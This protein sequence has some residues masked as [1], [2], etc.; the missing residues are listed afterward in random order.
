MKKKITTLPR[1]QFCTRFLRKL[2]SFRTS[3]PTVA[4]IL[5]EPYRRELCANLLWNC[6]TAGPRLAG[7]SSRRRDFWTA[8][9]EKAIAGAEALALIAREND[10]PDFAELML[11]ARQV[12]L[13]LQRR[14]LAAFPPAQERGRGG[15]DWGAVLYARRMLEGYLGGEPISDATLATLL[16]VA[17]EVLG[18][19]AVTK[20]AVRLGLARLKERLPV[21]EDTLTQFCARGEK[22]PL[23]A[24]TQLSQK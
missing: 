6:E 13:V 5:K 21:A 18:R 4:L 17:A 22:F 1:E 3:D 23:P 2:Q 7:I 8:Q 19:K 20:N 10:N 11:R 15:R 9:Y 12:V 24:R 16:D 14:L